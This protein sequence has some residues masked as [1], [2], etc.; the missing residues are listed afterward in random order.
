V[1]RDEGT[2]ARREEKKGEA[3]ADSEG[4]VGDQ[5]GAEFGEDGGCE[6]VWNGGLARMRDVEDAIRTRVISRDRIAET[7][8]GETDGGLADLGF[9]VG[10]AP[11]GRELLAP[12]DDGDGGETFEA[13]VEGVEGLLLV[14]DDVRDRRSVELLPVALE[15]GLA[16]EIRVAWAVLRAVA[17]D[18]HIRVPVDVRR[19]LLAVSAVVLVLEVAA[20]FEAAA[21]G[22]E[23]E[24]AL[25][26]GRGLL[27]EGLHGFG[28]RRAGDLA[29]RRR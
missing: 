27:E 18:V 24:L 9:A 5:L 1:Q 20:V 13:E 17:V 11:D 7:G 16:L 22:V 4:D 19:V 15:H 6:A 21:E 29:A 28:R 25:G 14:D 10:I 23:L 8:S 3:Y 2:R 26:L 12:A